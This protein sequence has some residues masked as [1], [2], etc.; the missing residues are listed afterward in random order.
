[1]ALRRRVIN[2]FVSCYV[3]VTNMSCNEVNNGYFSAMPEY[4]LADSL[5]LLKE[6][7]NSITFKNYG[8]CLKAKTSSCSLMPFFC[9]TLCY[10]NDTI[11]FM[12]D[13]K[14]LKFPFL[15]LT[16]ERY[17]SWFIEYT[18]ERS[19]SVVSLGMVADQSNGDSIM[20]YELIPIH[21]GGPSDAG[22]I[23]YIS[24]GKE[25]IRYLTY[26]SWGNNT[27]IQLGKYP[28][29]VFEER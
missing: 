17:K 8:D 23:K 21:R 27:T 25:G 28:K 16:D 2:V 13:D 29:V 1:M 24:L 22:F 4:F 9:G 3:V 10:R 26:S 15:I 12:K 7:F 18:P 11:Y 5:D 19:D 6:T 14:G 20:I